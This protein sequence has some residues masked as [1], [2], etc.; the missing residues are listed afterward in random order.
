MMF[1]LVLHL[2]IFVDFLF[3]L[4]VHVYNTRFSCA[5][6]LF[7]QKSR[8]H[9]HNLWNLS[10]SLRLVRHYGT[11]YTQIGVSSRKE[12]LKEKFISC[13]YCNC[14][15]DWGLLCWRPFSDIEFKHKNWIVLISYKY[16]H[17]PPRLVLLPAGM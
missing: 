5:D 14:T 2:K 6:N 17:D 3:I 10:L 12:H 7:V 11:V 15:W 9:V 16:K 1:L 4:H 13:F 8:L